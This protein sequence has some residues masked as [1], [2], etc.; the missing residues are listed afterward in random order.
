MRDERPRSPTLRI[1]REDPFEAG[2]QAGLKDGAERIRAFNGVEVRRIHRRPGDPR[3]LSAFAGWAL[4]RLEARP[5]FQTF[6]E[7]RGL[8]SDRVLHLRG[9]AEGGGVTRAEAALYS[10]LH[11][12]HEIEALWNSL[13][14]GSHPP[15]ARA[16]SAMIFSGSGVILG[17]HNADSVPEPPMLP[18]PGNVGPVRFRVHPQRRSTP[19]RM[20]LTR[21]RTGYIERW[22]V[23]NEKG[24]LILPGLSCNTWLDEPIEDTW[25]VH[26]VPVLRFA[27]SARHAAQLW[28]RYNRHQYRAGTFLILDRAG[29][30]VAVE[31]TFR[32]IGLRFPDPRGY[33]CAT[34]GHFEEPDM[35]AYRFGRTADYVRRTGL[36]SGSIDMQ[37]LADC[38]ARY[39]RLCELGG[40]TVNR[41]VKTL[42]A[43]M[44][45]HAP[46]PR[47][48]CRHAD[49]PGG[50]D[51]TVTM[52]QWIVDLAADR[53]Y[54][55]AWVP[56]RAFCCRQPWKRSA[57][58]SRP[59]FR[60]T[61]FGV[62]P[63]L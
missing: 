49:Q 20:E 18:P 47:N 54:H 53:A 63:R 28:Q 40:Q 42:A 22:G 13:Q 23:T 52:Q 25:P 2:R 46:F 35:H 57:I 4:E 12:R 39:T 48:L 29:G 59:D 31:K 17:A 3:S 37:Y 41:T 32:R 60:L 36:G 5:D 38:H 15:L 55:R 21:P 61:H 24:V 7:L 19:R 1:R 51:Q 6:P 9:L 43:L 26:Q 45:D 44:S 50:Y 30:A 33:L 11:F 10:Y 8:H 14:I 34:D 16:C 27:R 56:G 58:L 62:I